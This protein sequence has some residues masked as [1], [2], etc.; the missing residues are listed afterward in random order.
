MIRY[1]FCFST[2]CNT[3]SPLKISVIP[4][5]KRSQQKCNSTQNTSSSTSIPA[6]SLIPEI[7]AFKQKKIVGTDNTTTINNAGKGSLPKTE[8][9]LHLKSTIDSADMHRS[10]DCIPKKVS[11]QHHSKE[12][13]YWESVDLD[14][15]CRLNWYRLRI[16]KFW[17]V[18]HLIRILR[19]APIQMQVPVSHRWKFLVRKT[20]R[21]CVQIDNP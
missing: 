13:G 10:V 7:P 16:Q 18:L 12:L 20:P 3:I 4:P 19:Y 15:S 1:L 14:I 17:I 21:V 2:Q 11:Y 8:W 9:Q 6:Y 5:F